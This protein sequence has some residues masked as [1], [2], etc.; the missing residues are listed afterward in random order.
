MNPATEYAIRTG[1]VPAV[2]VV[3]TDGSV[4]AV[5]L[6]RARREYL[7]AHPGIRSRVVTKMS[8]T[9]PRGARPK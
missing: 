2:A 8:A 3:L 7:G 9:L 1:R 6:H 4:I 5:P